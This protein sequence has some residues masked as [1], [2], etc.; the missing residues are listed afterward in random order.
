MNAF[1]LRADYPG[2]T[3]A[4][5][6]EWEDDATALFGASGSGKSTILEALAGLRRDVRGRVE[7]RGRRLEGLPARQR[8]VG[9]VPQDA[10]LFPWM[11]ARE[12]VDFAVRA[13][14]DAAAAER[15]IE[16]L[17]LGSL[18]DRRAARLSGG[19]RQRVAIARALASR[20]EFLLLDEPLAS[21]D[22]PLRARIVPFL[23]RIPAELG[24]PLL[25]VTHDPLEVAALTRHVVVVEKGR[26]VASGAPSAIFSAPAAFGSFDTVGAENSFP[27]TV[28][29]R[30][31]GLLEV[32]T[33]N[34]CALR[35]ADVPGFP[36]PER[37][38]IRAAAIVVATRRP[39][40][41]LVENVLEGTVRAVANAGEQ[42]ELRVDAGGESWRVRT[43]RHGSDAA[44]LVP[45]REAWLLIRAADLVPAA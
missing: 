5:A 11:S 8:A 36:P 30:S 32:A 38:A 26:V 6:A 45:G 17:E 20:P 24:V 34:G 1:E 19:E 3:L 27:V 37:V 13:R 23:A 28:R 15:A 44:A 4:A 41:V 35:M 39:E 10:S 29:A 9:W 14:G 33:R 31:L 43:S 25:L 18:L 22:R 12:N 21:I 2:F 42:L 7:L 16:V 40:S